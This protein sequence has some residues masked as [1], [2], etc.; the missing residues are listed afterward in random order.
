MDARDR[1]SHMSLKLNCPYCGKQSYTE[2]PGHIEHCRL[3]QKYHGMSLHELKLVANVMETNIL[4][5]PP[6][7]RTL[8]RK[9]THDMCRE[10]QYREKDCEGV[11]CSKSK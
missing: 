10:L 3:K 7:K 4:S 1:K 11:I 2:E 5:T 9:L 8:H 6:D